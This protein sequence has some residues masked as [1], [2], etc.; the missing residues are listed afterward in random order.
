M[1]DLD[2]F[3]IIAKGNK[4]LIVFGLMAWVYV[5]FQAAQF[6]LFP[7]IWL[8][9]SVG[10]SFRS[11]NESVLQTVLAAFVYLVTVLIVMGIPWL[12]HKT[13]VSMKE[14]GLDRLP[15]W[16]DI[17]LVPAG[18]VIYL[19]ISV[20]ISTLA[21]TFLPWFNSNQA[22]DVGFNGLNYGYEYI[23]AFITL[24]I[25]AP[26]AEEVLF[27]GYLLGKLVKAIPA[28]VAV[29]AVSSL[30]GFIHG[31][32]NLA[33]DTFALSVILSTLRLR[34]GGLWTPILIHMTKNAIAFYILF[35]N[36]SLLLQ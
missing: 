5:S 12:V 13:K 17:M 4:P 21:T 6:L 24:V 30:F 9:D 18:F 15:T 2:H 10:L 29:L 14:L 27:R 1:K 20:I 16:T 22:Q 11:V 3:K 7:I 8:T 28:W 36:T 25:I 32:W 19:V 35:I 34:T 23:L 31:A 26:V 33:F